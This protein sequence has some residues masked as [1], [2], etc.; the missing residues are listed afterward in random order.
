[1]N[2]GILIFNGAEELDFMGPWEMLSLWHQ[3]ADGPNC[4]LVAQSSAAVIC[5]NGMSVNPTTDFEH[6]PPL[7]YLFIPGGQGTR[8][9][10]NNSVLV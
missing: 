5:A 10:V 1:M 4:L 9:E 6:C 2:A 8:T 7:D 3:L